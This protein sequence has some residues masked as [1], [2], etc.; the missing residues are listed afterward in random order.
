MNPVQQE[1]NREQ[2][3][4]RQQLEYREHKNKVF[5][6]LILDSSIQE[7]AIIKQSSNV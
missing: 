7:P 6:D 5:E 1:I 2:Q 3:L 4:V